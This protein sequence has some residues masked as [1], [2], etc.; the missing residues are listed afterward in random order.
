[1]TEAMAKEVITADVV[2]SLEKVTIENIDSKI[3]DITNHIKDII[4][5]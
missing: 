5:D 1:V 2:E 4:E 3:T